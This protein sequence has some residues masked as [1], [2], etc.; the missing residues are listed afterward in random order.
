[1]SKDGSDSISSLYHIT[2]ILIFPVGLNFP[3]QRPRRNHSKRETIRKQGREYSETLLPEPQRLQSVTKIRKF[4][5]LRGFNK[6]RENETET[7]PQ[8]E[9]K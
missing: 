6:G 3:N 9:S 8:Q 2:L 1:M 4:P 7:W 5:V